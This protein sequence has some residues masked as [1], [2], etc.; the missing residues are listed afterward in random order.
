MLL[1]AR[2]LQ[3][4]S[5]RPPHASFF[6][7]EKIEEATTRPAVT[8]KAIKWF[9]ATGPAAFFPTERTTTPQPPQRPKPA[10]TR[11]PRLDASKEN[12]NKVRSDHFS[13]EYD[14]E[15]QFDKK[16]SSDRNHQGRK[17]GR[18]DLFSQFDQEIRGQFDKKLKPKRSSKASAKSIQQHHREPDFKPRSDLMKIEGLYCVIDTSCLYSVHPTHLRQRRQP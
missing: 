1:Q 6:N 14:F 10:K 17:K 7:S 3:T 16:P 13:S 5:R 9:T 2:I 11:R 8:T 18:S 4:S 12:H 15:G